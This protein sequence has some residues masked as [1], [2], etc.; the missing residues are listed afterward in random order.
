QGQPFGPFGR[1]A[2]D[3]ESDRGSF[4]IGDV[5]N[6]A[7]LLCDGEISCLCSQ[8]VTLRPINES[9]DLH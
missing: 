1:S 6:S 9:I 8:I 5:K 7:A 4:E 3:G 2:R